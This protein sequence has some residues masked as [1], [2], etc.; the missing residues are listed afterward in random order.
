MCTVRAKWWPKAFS[1]SLS[2]Y[3]YWPVCCR[4]AFGEKVRTNRCPADSTFF[5]PPFGICFFEMPVAMG[6]E[7]AL[8]P[9][10]VNLNLDLPGEFKPKASSSNLS[11]Y[12]CWPVSCRK[13]ACKKPRKNGCR[14]DSSFS[15]SLGHM[16]LCRYWSA[17]FFHSLF[18][19]P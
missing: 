17:L 8:H 15:I 3:L 14:A 13:R 11:L 4:K 2:L 12:P 5:A 10:K 16:L 9:P 19:H 7:S 1:E 6:F 18:A